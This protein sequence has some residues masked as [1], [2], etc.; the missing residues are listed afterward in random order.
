M[1]RKRRDKIRAKDLQGLKYFQKLLPL[2]DRLHEYRLEQDKAGNRILHYDRYPAWILLFFCNPIVTSMRGWCSS[3]GSAPR[4]Q[5][6][7]DFAPAAGFCPHSEP[8]AGYWLAPGARVLVEIFIQRTGRALTA[9]TPLQAAA[10]R[11]VEGFRRV[12]RARQEEPRP[13]AGQ[14]GSAGRAPRYWHF[15]GR[16]G[17][18]KQPWNSRKSAT[19]ASVSPSRSAFA[20]V[21]PRVLYGRFGPLKQSWK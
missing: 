16:L 13:A 1:A 11:D 12:A 2:P 8:C 7:R 20:Q 14:Q 15:G 17:P 6:R 21:G 5:R 18:L 9:V 4:T 19:S 10:F 3:A